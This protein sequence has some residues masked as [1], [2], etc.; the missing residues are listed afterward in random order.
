MMEKEVLISTATK[1]SNGV[2]VAVRLYETESNIEV[3]LLTAETTT[4]PLRNHKL[5]HSITLSKP[6]QPEITNQDRVDK[7][8][9]L[10]GE[11]VD[12]KTRND[13]LEQLNP[14]LSHISTV[15]E[16]NKEGEVK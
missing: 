6:K 12:A 16:S 14:L 8:A 5:Y 10:L 9:Y 7:I 2:S 11:N 1:L 4:T 13:I 15:I 3:K